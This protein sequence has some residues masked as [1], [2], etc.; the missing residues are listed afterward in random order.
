MDPRDRRLLPFVGSLIPTLVVSA[1]VAAAVRLPGGAY[2]I[3]G[4]W[5]VAMS[6]LATSVVFSTL[7]VLLARRR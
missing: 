7:L 3:E 6:G 2:D 5:V 4:M 1:L